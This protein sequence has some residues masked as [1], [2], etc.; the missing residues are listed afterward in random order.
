MSGNA[1]DLSTLMQQI[2]DPG[3]VLSNHE[4]TPYTYVISSFEGQCE[5]GDL[6]FNFQVGGTPT[7]RAHVIALRSHGTSV[8]S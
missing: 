6:E 5:L 2:E 8:T 3:Q 7:H 4:L 1:E